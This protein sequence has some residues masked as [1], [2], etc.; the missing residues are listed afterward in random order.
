MLGKSLLARL[1]YWLL[2]RNARTAN[3]SHN[4][5]VRTK[6]PKVTRSVLRQNKAPVDLVSVVA[7]DGRKKVVRIATGQVADTPKNERSDVRVPKK[8]APIVKSAKPEIP[9]GAARNSADNH[10]KPGH[11]VN[12]IP[13]TNKK[14]ADHGEKIFEQDLFEKTERNIAAAMKEARKGISAEQL[15]IRF[16]LSVPEAGLIASMRK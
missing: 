2:M 7:S 15:V 14:I 9:T 8:A 16:G 12:Q 10:S 5:P 11:G 1:G 13:T 6:K 3:L 4:A